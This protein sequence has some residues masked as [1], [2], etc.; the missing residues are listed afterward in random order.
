M[1]NQNIM[2][3]ILA[4]SLWVASAMFSSSCEQERMLPD[5]P[6]QFPRYQ[7]DLTMHSNIL[8][9]TLLYSVFLPADY[10]EHPENRYG[11]VYLLHGLGD[12]HQSWNDKYLNICSAIEQMEAEN[13][14]PPMIYV[15]PQGFRSYYVNR[16]N[17]SYSYMD[18]FANEL[19]SFIDR[20]YRSIPDRTKRAAVGYSM[21]GY[22]AMILPSKHP[23]LF[24]VAV[25]LSMSFRTNQQYITEPASGWD[26]QWGAIFGGMGTSDTARL[27]DY[28]KAHCP[29]YM[30]NAQS[31]SSFA[32]VSYFLDCGDD[33][34][35][36]LV[37]NDD[38]HVLLRDLGI[39]HEYRVRNG[40]H[41]SSYWRSAMFEALP[42]IATRF[43]N[44]AY[45]SETQLAIPSNYSAVKENATLASAP[46]AVFLPK[47]YHSE[48][49]KQ[50]PAIYLIY[51]DNGAFS[52]E[53]VMKVLDTLQAAKPFV[54]VA[55][56]ASA[57]QPPSSGFQS[58][59]AEASSSYRLK[60]GAAYAIGIAYG[61]GGQ[62][63]YDAAQAEAIS[64][65]FLVDAALNEPLATPKSSAYYFIAMGDDGANY[66]SAN[67]IYKQCHATAAPFEYR[68]QNGTSSKDAILSLFDL[69][70]KSLQEKIKIN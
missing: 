49:G 3:Q 7:T 47:N 18:M 32:E 22:G 42:Y 39:S 30:F 70:K 65:L 54:L 16:Y 33:E 53:D 36:L 61:L 38:L 43:D 62:I 26:G 6:Q 24:S 48:T 63:L 52:P 58:L 8:G 57:I 34:E 29:F 27:T 37:A 45:S 4:I 14:L 68:V 21:G 44:E 23:E 51:E 15:M 66:R 1:K 50:Y 20:S 31:A 67:A 56:S 55:C 10:V 46:V 69:L 12:N 35:Q 11:V 19:V 17:G 28:Y 9:I 25:P 2:N 60:A 41:Q 64:A 59:V 5:K 40:A 13:G